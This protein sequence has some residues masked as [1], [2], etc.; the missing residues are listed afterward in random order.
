ML[1]SRRGKK[2]DKDQPS[3]QQKEKKRVLQAEV[4]AEDKAT[5]QQGKAS[6]ASVRVSYGFSMVSGQHSKAEIAEEF[7]ARNAL[8]WNNMKA[9]YNQSIYQKYHDNH[10]LRW[11][12]RN[13]LFNRNK[14][15]AAG[16][17]A[18]S[19]SKNQLEKKNQGLEEK[20]PDR[21]A[22]G[23]STDYDME[24]DENMQKVLAILPPLTALPLAPS[25]TPQPPATS[26]RA[27]LQEPPPPSKEEQ[28]S[29]SHKGIH[30]MPPASDAG[31]AERLKEK[32]LS[33][34]VQAVFD[35]QKKW[36]AAKTKADTK[37]KRQAAP[38]AGRPVTVLPGL[39]PTTSGAEA[40]TPSA[41]Q[42]KA[43]QETLDDTEH[44]VPADSP[45]I[46]V[47]TLQ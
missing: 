18:Y 17:R 39:A 38:E 16:S 37:K 9:W 20:V 23:D 28:A 2:K 8:E 1:G 15:I 45:A 41:E 32:L 12:A 46:H 42:L 6:A 29:L 25:M 19:L 47:L 5:G 35:E 11:L 7:H 27:G 33:P 22:Q 21:S 40:P 26:S 13:S 44:L 3:L 14:A 10:V 34:S 30:Y 43:I 31:Q 24:G 4:R 36:D